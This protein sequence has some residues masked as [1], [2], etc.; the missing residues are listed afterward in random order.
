MYNARPNPTQTY[1]NNTAQVQLYAVDSNVFFIGG[2][3][4]ASLPR[5]GT[6][7]DSTFRLVPASLNG[8]DSVLTDVVRGGVPRCE[9]TSGVAERLRTTAA[10]MRRRAAIVV[11][12][13]RASAWHV[14]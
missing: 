7:S 10:S 6:S 12:D 8:D 13:V 5:P 11:A 1:S 3:P 9:D 2:D 14:A 4:S